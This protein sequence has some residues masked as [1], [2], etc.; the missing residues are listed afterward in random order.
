MS[1]AHNLQIIKREHENSLPHGASYWKSSV[2]RCLSDA[3]GVLA[4]I[5]VRSLFAIVL[6]FFVQCILP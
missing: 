4:V 2:I 1:Y 5:A 6:A 3:G